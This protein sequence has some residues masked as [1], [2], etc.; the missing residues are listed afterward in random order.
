[1]LGQLPT[2]IF[3]NDV[4]SALPVRKKEV[5]GFRMVEMTENHGSKVRR[6]AEGTAKGD[7]S[8]CR[9]VEV[10]GQES[11]DHTC[12]RFKWCGN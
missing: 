10:R 11:L 6:I 5:E 12:N 2:S 7:S 4:V 8:E 9:Q 3:R 1:M